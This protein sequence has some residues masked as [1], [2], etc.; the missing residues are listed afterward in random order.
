MHNQFNIIRIKNIFKFE[1]MYRQ[2]LTKKKEKKYIISNI[3]ALIDYFNN[4]IN[5]L[6]LMKTEIDIKDKLINML[7]IYIQNYKIPNN[8]IYNFI[9]VIL[10]Y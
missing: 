9:K 8:I 3:I 5:K 10:K 1:E 7:K 4:H 2:I 6:S